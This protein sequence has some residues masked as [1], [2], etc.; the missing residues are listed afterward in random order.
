MY[1][2]VIYVY[3]VSVLEHALTVHSHTPHSVTC[4]CVLCA[5]MTMWVKKMVFTSSCPGYNPTRRRKNRFRVNP[6]VCQT[7]RRVNPTYVCKAVGSRREASSAV[8]CLSAS[9]VWA[10]VLLVWLLLAPRRRRGPDPAMLSLSLSSS[11]VCAR[12]RACCARLCRCCCL[13]ALSMCSAV[14]MCVVVPPKI[15]FCFCIH[16]TSLNYMLHVHAYDR[17]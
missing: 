15:K 5:T 13:C 7:L 4:L 14:R 8:C 17:C 12:A 10:P 16:H 11:C 9:A 2:H 1:V 6:R 3:F